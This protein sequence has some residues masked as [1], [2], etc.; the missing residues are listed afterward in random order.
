MPETAEVFLSLPLPVRC[1]AVFVEADMFLRER[2]ADGIADRVE[3]G[4]R[5]IYPVLDQSNR[6]GIWDHEMW[7]ELIAS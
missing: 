1:G 5:V 4:G 7:F 3:L 2:I 6:L